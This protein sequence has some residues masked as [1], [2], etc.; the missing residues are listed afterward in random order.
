[1]RRTYARL[2]AVGALAVVTVIFAG[3]ALAGGNP[4]A[5]GQQKK[6]AE[7]QQ[8]STQSEGSASAAASM[9][10]TVSASASVSVVSHASNGHQSHHGKTHGAT[11]S[12]SGSSSTQAG[13]KPGPT[14]T[15]WTHCTTGGTASAATCTSS[16][17]GHTPQT[18]AD[19]SKLYGN[20]KTAA[21]IAVSRGGVN[22]QLTGPGN[23]QPHKVTACGEPSNPSGGVDVHAVKSYSNSAC[24][25]AAAAATARS[26]SITT[27]ASVS[28]STPPAQPAAR[29]PVHAAATAP[30]ANGVLG[31]H[32]TLTPKHHAA[33]HGVLGTVT[34]I[35][36]STLPF[37]GF[38]LWLVALAAMAL[39]AAGV[40][41]R[42]A[43]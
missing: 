10:T 18:S 19:V 26:S 24:S 37:T 33:G 31:A 39:A 14:T 42:R 16:D 43:V 13:V 9:S 36:A 27:P 8:Q 17:S 23:S 21:Q 7:Q 5:P 28:V 4:N 6:E 15:H 11:A 40:A 25:P 35:G 12:A 34:R 3:T 41:L 2:A 22:V 29:A 20:G 32:V 38:R 30:P 1:M